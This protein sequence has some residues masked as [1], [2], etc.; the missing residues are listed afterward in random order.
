MK[1]SKDII[2]GLLILRNRQAVPLQPP[3]SLHFRLHAV[4]TRQVGA[5]SRWTSNFAEA[6]AFA[7]GRVAQMERSAGVSPAAARIAK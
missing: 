7:K 3:P 5:A 6:S 4:S 1:L 2:A